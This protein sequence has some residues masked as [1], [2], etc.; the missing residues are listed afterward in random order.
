MFSYDNIVCQK[1]R[2][3]TVIIC[4]ACKNRF[5]SGCRGLAYFS[6]S[7]DSVICQK[8]LLIKEKKK[9]QKA[10]VGKKKKKAKEN[11]KS[12]AY[13]VLFEKLKRNPNYFYIFE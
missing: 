11:T 9:N 3:H 7:E 8:Y 2:D 13:V 1:S 10:I 12:Y 4:F 6:R 5:T